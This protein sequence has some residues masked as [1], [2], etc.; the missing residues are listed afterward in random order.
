MLF[1]DIL[2][3]IVSLAITGVVTIAI[4]WVSIY[5]VLDIISRLKKYRKNGDDWRIDLQVLGFRVIR[6]VTATGGLRETN[7]MRKDI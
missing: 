1:F 3:G 6:G 7:A 5:I 4:L 2:L